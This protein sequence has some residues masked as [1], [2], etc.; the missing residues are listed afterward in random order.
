MNAEQFNKSHTE[1]LVRRARNLDNDE[2][3]A[4]LREAPIEGLFYALM[5]RIMKILDTNRMYERVATE[6][7]K[8]YEDDSLTEWI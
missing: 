6:V 3:K 4:I 1:E 8:V 2:W 5:H 7:E